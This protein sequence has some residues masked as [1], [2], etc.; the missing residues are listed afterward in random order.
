MLGLAPSPSQSEETRRRAGF[1]P[2]PVFYGARMKAWRLGN[3][4]VANMRPPRVFTA[5]SSPSHYIYRQVRRWTPLSSRGESHIIEAAY[6]ISALASPWLDHGVHLQREPYCGTVRKQPSPSGH[7]W[8]EKHRS[9][10]LRQQRFQIRFGIRKRRRRDRL[11]RGNQLARDH[12]VHR[13]VD[14]IG[15]D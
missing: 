4:R 8:K 13:P 9:L 6:S 15:R 7:R 2:R 5:A 14:G 1:R 10:A 11:A 3:I 12:M